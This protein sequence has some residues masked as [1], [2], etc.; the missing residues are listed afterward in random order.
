MAV[1]QMDLD[2]T[3]L[4]RHRKAEGP[5][6][7]SPEALA[8]LA[9]IG[10]EARVVGDGAPRI[11]GGMDFRELNP[12]EAKLE[13]TAHLLPSLP[14]PPLRS[15]TLISF[16]QPV[17][18]TFPK[19]RWRSQYV[20]DEYFISCMWVGGRAVITRGGSAAQPCLGRRG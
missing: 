6:P 7:H 10:E 3:V 15:L 9:G 20:R 12:R 4:L 2:P 19:S 17:S 1:G 16:P 18:F 14:P 11:E 5:T 13:V 8:L